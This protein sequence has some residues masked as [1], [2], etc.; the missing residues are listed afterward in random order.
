[1]GFDTRDLDKAIAVANSLMTRADGRCFCRLSPASGLQ[2][3]TA[4]AAQALRLAQRAA[5]HLQRQVLLERK[6]AQARELGGQETGLLARKAGAAAGA[7]IP[8][9]VLREIEALQ[10]DLA[11]SPPTEAERACL[12]AAAFGTYARPP[13][14]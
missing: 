11:L 6:F 1:M 14:L 4:R 2:E 5:P 7:A 10:Q 3:I 12:Q 13:A 9:E 8:Q